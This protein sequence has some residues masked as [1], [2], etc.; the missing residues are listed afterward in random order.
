MQAC[1]MARASTSLWKM[2]CSCHLMAV[3]PCMLHLAE[4]LF[5]EIP[6]KERMFPEESKGN[7]GAVLGWH[8]R[9]HA[10]NAEALKR[11]NAERGPRVKEVY[12]KVGLS[13]PIGCRF[14]PLQLCMH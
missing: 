4:F 3:I 10:I 7:A 5:T 8:L 1:P 2:V 14:L 12:T 9:Q 6:M 13:V 11:F